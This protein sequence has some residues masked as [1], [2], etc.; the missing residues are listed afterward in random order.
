[1]KRLLPKHIAAPKFLHNFIDC[2]ETING[3]PFEVNTPTHTPRG[4]Y[5]CVHYGVMIPNLNAP[6]NFL[7]LFN[8]G[9][10]TTCKNF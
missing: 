1:M 4:K 7:N 2:S 8:R 10:S 3:K 9:W 6:F 5:S